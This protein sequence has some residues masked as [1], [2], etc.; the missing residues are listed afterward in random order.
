MCQPRQAR[1]Q[2]WA[3]GEG[4]VVRSLG[5]GRGGGRL[6]PSLPGPPGPTWLPPS[7][8]GPRAPELCTQASPACLPPAFCL[9]SRHT[10]PCP[11]LTGVWGGWAA[12]LPL[13]LS[14]F[15]GTPLPKPLQKWRRAWPAAPREGH[16]GAN[17]GWAL[18][19]EAG[20]GRGDAA[21]R[22]GFR[23]AGRWEGHRGRHPLR[24]PP[25][26]P[27]WRLGRGAPL[28]KAA[29][30]SGRKGGSVCLLCPQ[31]WAL[32]LQTG[33][34]QGAGGSRPGSHGGA[35]DQQGPGLCQGEIE[36]GGSG[37]KRG[38]VRG[39]PHPTSSPQH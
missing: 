36:F 34:M 33:P 4:L 13:S 23:R 26:P 7:P 16:V 30:A 22:W 21:T 1:G 29:P 35:G 31:E 3:R 28:A 10:Q 11:G 14:G 17:W 24:G 6:E 39:C 27:E 15:P 38:Q 25:F 19:Q 8:P 9:G 18:G 32:S 12:R 2:R 5:G 20:L 37:K